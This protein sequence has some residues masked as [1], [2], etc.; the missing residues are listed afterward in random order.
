MPHIELVF[1]LRLLLTEVLLD[2]RVAVRDEG[3]DLNAAL[4]QGGDAA[5]Q[6]LLFHPRTV[7]HFVALQTLPFFR[8]RYKVHMGIMDNIDFLLLITV[9]DC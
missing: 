4:G 7:A 8:V 1:N 2:G 9:L 5:D 6:A 3:A